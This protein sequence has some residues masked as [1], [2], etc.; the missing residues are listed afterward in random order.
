[1]HNQLT[2]DER[3]S[4][5]AV[6]RTHAAMQEQRVME[7]TDVMARLRAEDPEASKQLLDEMQE[8]NDI[9]D[10]DSCE[11]NRIADKIE[12]GAH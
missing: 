5:V 4:A 2:A 11:L 9:I 1:M 12:L 8:G 7:S 3:A 6:L 10:D